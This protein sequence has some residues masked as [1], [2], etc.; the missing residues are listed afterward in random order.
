MENQM[1]VPK[2]MPAVVIKAPGGPEVL[3]AEEVATPVPASTE[4]LIEVAAAGVNRPDCLQRQGLYPLPPGA[5]SLPGLEVAGTVVAIGEQVREWQIGDKVIALTHGG[6]YAKYCVANEGHCLPWPDNLTHIEAAA[7]AE[8]T[9]TVQSNLFNR[10]RL[11]AGESVLIH[12]GSSGIGATAIQLAKLSGAR[13]FVTAGSQAKCEFCLNLGADVAINYKESEWDSELAGLTDG[14]GIDVVLD[15]VAGPYVAKNLQALKEDG[16]YSMIAFLL[17][18]KTEVNFAPI[19]TKRLSLFGSTLRP[20]SV[21]QKTLI[22][23]SV[24]DKVWPHLVSGD[25]VVPIFEQFPLA[26]AGEAHQL[27]ESSSHMGKIV[28]DLANII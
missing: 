13:V 1:S 8:T 2:M 21:A 26:S 7:V 3:V 16:R 24:R 27:M 11:V 18:P 17:G 9:F 14:K 12:G 4:V 6:G 15:M 22:R 25:F 20:Q 19:L 5:S 23:D 10:A 28:L